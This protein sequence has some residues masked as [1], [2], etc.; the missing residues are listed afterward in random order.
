VQ[1]VWFAIQTVVAIPGLIFMTPF[2]LLAWY[3]LFRQQTSGLLLRP[4]TI[5]AI[6]MFITMSLIFTFPGMR[7]AL[8]HSSVALW[9][10]TMAL[11]AAGIGFAVDWVAAR[12]S[13]WKPERAK[14]NFAGLFVVVALV[15]SV[16]VSGVGPTSGEDPEIFR[17]IG[18][19]IPDASVVMAGN[20]PAFFYHT[21]HPAI[22]IPN[23]SI[24]IVLEA[25]DR[26]QVNY[27]ILNQNRPE[28]LSALYSGEE[29]SD[30]L[31]LLE[32]VADIK[33]FEL[34]K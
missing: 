32:S 4:V 21:G 3:R 20:A 34:T 22:S 25:A 6:T 8:F 10:W 14:R 19:L 33:L 12:L 5:Y 1:G 9:P 16:A 27:I 18:G 29:Q 11:A 13:H 15:V 30:R 24:E 7:G 17:H 26:Y 2:I 23:E 31:R 28:P